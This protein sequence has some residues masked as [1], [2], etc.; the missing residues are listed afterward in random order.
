MR[1]GSVGMSRAISGS[2]RIMPTPDR[3][4]QGLIRTPINTEFYKLGIHDHHRHQ[5]TALKLFK[6]GVYLI[7]K[8]LA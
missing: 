3:A 8:R 7:T 5:E 1:L 2:Q 6:F 4:R